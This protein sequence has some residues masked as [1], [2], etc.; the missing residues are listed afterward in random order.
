[1][2]QR[3]AQAFRG[4]DADRLAASVYYAG[5]ALV[6]LSRRISAAKCVLLSRISNSGRNG[7]NSG[8]SLNFRSITRT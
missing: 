7:P 4:D 8:A 1:M 5:K 2:Q 3:L 6:A